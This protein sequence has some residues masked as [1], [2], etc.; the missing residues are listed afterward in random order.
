M[1][2]IIFTWIFNICFIIIMYYLLRKL[3]KKCYL[4]R[5]ATH[6]YQHSSK[7]ENLEKREL[8]EVEPCNIC[9]EDIK[10]VY[11]MPCSSLHYFCKECLVKWMNKN[12]QILTCPFRCDSQV[13]EI[14]LE[15][16]F[17]PE[18]LSSSDE[19][20]LISLPAIVIDVDKVFP[21]DHD[22]VIGDIRLGLDNRYYIKKE[23]EPYWEYIDINN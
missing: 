22:V 6:T 11:I 12:D 19:I 8:D 16:V 7:I 9:M 23:D 13:T 14:E 2:T 10:K 4:Q 3:Y 1:D 5:Y 21:S 15:T 18:Q 20:H 17:E